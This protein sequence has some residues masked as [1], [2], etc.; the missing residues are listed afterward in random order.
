MSH[1]KIY[2]IEIV[3]GQWWSRYAIKFS[4]ETVKQIEFI[5]EIVLPK[6]SKMNISVMK[7]NK[8]IISRKKT[9]KMDLSKNQRDSS[10]FLL[11]PHQLMDNVIN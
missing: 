11:L 6:T 5:Q 9:L 4:Q 1:Q 2:N 8:Q 10:L 3:C 7:K